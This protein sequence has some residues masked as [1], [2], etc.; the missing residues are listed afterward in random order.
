MESLF[1]YLGWGKC[2]ASGSALRIPVPFFITPMYK[3][4]LSWA[5]PPNPS[6]V[7]H[8]FLPEAFRGPQ[9]QKAPC[10][11]FSETAP[12]RAFYPVRSFSCFVTFFLRHLLS[13]KDS[14]NR[15]TVSLRNP[16]FSIS[17]SI[18]SALS[19]LLPHKKQKLPTLPF[20]PANRL[21]ALP[22]TFPLRNTPR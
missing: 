17:F 9:K 21:S 20:L 18:V 12:P 19:D 13:F 4:C 11:F 5:S 3:I 7:P 1:F 15:A 8:F 10:F 16:M 22:L 6:L 2:S 14:P